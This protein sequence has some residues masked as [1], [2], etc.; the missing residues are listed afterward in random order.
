MENKINKWIKITL[1]MLGLAAS[2]LLSGVLGIRIERNRQN[3]IELQKENVSTIAVVNMDNGVVIDNE[4]IN[5]ASKLISFPNEHFIITGLSDAKAGIE[6]GAYAAYIVIPETFSSSVTSIE[7]DPGKVELVYQYNN[8]L[9]EETEIQA[10]NDVNT[11]IALL[12]SNI[13]YMYMDAIMA[14]FHR[15]QDESSTILENDNMERE[16]LASVKASDLI[17]SAVPVEEIEVTNDIEPV[18]LTTYTTRNDDL[19]DG[20]MLGYSEA[21]QTGKDDYATIQEENTGVQT[22]ADGFISAYDTVIQDTLTGQAELLTTGRDK[23]T[24][25]IGLYNQSVDEQEAGVRSAL[26]SVI[27]M[28]LEADKASA[29]T[30]LKGIVEGYRNIPSAVN[31]NL[32]QKTEACRIGLEELIHD[33]YIQGYNDAVSD[34]GGGSDS[35]KEDADAE[36]QDFKAAVGEQLSGIIIEWEQLPIELPILPED[37][38]KEDGS[39]EGSEDSGDESGEE[40]ELEI[41]LTVFEDEETVNTVVTNTLDLF[42]MEVESGQIDDVIQTY[43][44]DAL[45]EESAVQMGKMADEKLLLNQSIESYEALLI[46]Y[47]PMQY[48][49]NANLDTYLTDIELNAG[50]MYSAVEQNNSDYMSYASEMYTSTTEHTNQVKTALDEANA[51]TVINVE[52]CVGELILSREEVNS[53]NVSILGEF[54][55]ALWYTR[56]GSLENTEVYDYIVNPVVSMENGQT[57]K[58]ISEPVLKEDNSV[59]IL[60][61][62]ALGIG[63]MFFLIEAVISFYQQYKESIEERGRSDGRRKLENEL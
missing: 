30:Q 23:L 12:N 58:N 14:E 60:L 26:E 9:L 11:F 19:L 59:K 17:A 33:V 7:N 56:V 28:Q 29:Q 21:V 37:D 22:A 32:A 42:K 6:N 52:D 41:V 57:V 3:A 5:Y 8:K 20:M 34:L 63:I 15:I 1:C 35:M 38:E 54:P 27:N 53:Q 44:V 40:E 55:N 62:I 24:E 39:T 43:F 45:A 48:I 31:D 13:A 4:H 51:Q 49:E 10:V 18:E 25:A 2:L 36:I 46:N 50:D 16:H 47:D 61:V